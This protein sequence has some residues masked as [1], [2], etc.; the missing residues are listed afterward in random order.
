MTTATKRPLIPMRPPITVLHVCANNDVNGNPRRCFVI[1]DQ[2]GRHVE[3]LDEG[4]YGEGQ[5][6]ARY[7]WTSWHALSR[8]GFPEPA[9]YTTYPTRVD[10]TPS[11]YKRMLRREPDE[12]CADIRAMADRNARRQRRWENERRNRDRSF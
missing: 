6:Q 12:R 2:M 3:T 10:S 9:R 11:E 1:F 7:P 5:L 4:Y 8:Y